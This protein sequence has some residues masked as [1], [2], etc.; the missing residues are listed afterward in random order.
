MKLLHYISIYS[1]LLPILVF[2]IFPYNRSQKLKWVVF[3]LLALGVSID[4][5]SYSWAKKAL[6]NLVLI[7]LFT[8]IEGLL[9]SYFFYILFFKKRI[10][11]KITLFSGISLLS[12]WLVRN[13]F[14]QNILKYDYLSQAIEFIVLLLLCLLYFFQKAKVSDTVFIYS[15]FEFWLV[16]ALLIYC[17]GTFFSFFIPMSASEKEKDIIV[18]EYIS[19]FGSI[20]KNIL[21]TIAFCINPAKLSKNRPNPNSIY[22]IKDLKE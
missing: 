2:L 1:P 17:A 12:I 19:R 10:L 16:S 3:I 14:L 20:V 15:T 8:L 7:N 21:I 4:V 9:L 18:F 5:L 11:Q 22:Y 6:S 13:I